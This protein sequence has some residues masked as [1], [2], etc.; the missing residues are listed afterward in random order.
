MHCL[1]D[2]M[3]DAQLK[4]R[5]LPGVTSPLV[6]IATYGVPFALRTEQH[7]LGSIFYLH[8]GEP[9][10]W[11]LIFGSLIFNCTHSA[12]KQIRSYKCVK[13]T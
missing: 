11:Y 7:N 13:V 1:G 5:D 12:R 3:S 4:E 2:P 10:E 8:E 6:S 9:R